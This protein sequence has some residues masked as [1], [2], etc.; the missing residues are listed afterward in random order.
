[1][2][3]CNVRAIEAYRLEE[4]ELKKLKAILKENWRDW[5]SSGQKPA[6]Q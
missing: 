2:S 4:S 3:R 1:M 5:W 6:F